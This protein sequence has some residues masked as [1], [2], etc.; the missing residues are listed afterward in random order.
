MLLALDVGNSQ[1]FGGVFKDGKL[2]FK[3]RKTSKGYTTSDE[4]GIFFRSVLRENGLDPAELKEFAICSVVPDHIYPLSHSANKYF[5]LE[6]FVIQTGVKTGLNIKYKNPG[7][8]GADRITNAIAAT[9]MF[10]GKNLIIVD[11]G[12]ATTFCAIS[13]T[14]DYLGGVILPGLKISMEAL[15]RDTAKLPR[16]EI[17]KP[18]EVVGK[19]TITGIQSGLYYSHYFSIKGI[20]ERIKKD[21]FSDGQTVV[22]GTGGFSRVFEEDA[23]FDHIEPDLVLFGIA[24]AVKLNSKRKQ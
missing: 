17:I 5:N 19:S 22:L 8:V 18:P 15:A 16:V 4:F 10:E 1:V 7:E 20:V 6:P 21:Y 12:T 13:K 9:V 14:K 11:L 2:L 24:E 3:F 23:L